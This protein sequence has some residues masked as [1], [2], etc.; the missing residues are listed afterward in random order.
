M[1]GILRLCA[2]SALVA[3]LATACAASPCS[4]DAPLFCPHDNACCAASLPYHCVQGCYA[5]AEQAQAAC[6]GVNIDTCSR[7]GAQAQQDG[8]H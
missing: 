6:G 5:T 2:G 3:L 7:P 8:G 4:G 1:R